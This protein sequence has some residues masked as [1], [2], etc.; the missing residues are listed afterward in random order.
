MVD[1]WRILERIYNHYG[2]VIR[3]AAG[4]NYTKEKNGFLIITKSLQITCHIP[5]PIPPHP[6]PC[7]PLRSL[8]CL[9]IHS[10]F[11]QLLVL[12]S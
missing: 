7:L 11:Q 3:T 12:N 8:S 2:K 6:N 4:S 5:L 10:I 9:L 1:I